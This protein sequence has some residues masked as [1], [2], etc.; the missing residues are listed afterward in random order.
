MDFRKIILPAIGRLV[1]EVRT[2]NKEGEP[3]TVAAIRSKQAPV[4]A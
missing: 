4:K 2:S 3:L 1:V